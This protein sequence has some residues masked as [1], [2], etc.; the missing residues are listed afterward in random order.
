MNKAT[1]LSL[2]F[3]TILVLGTT[4][5]F[6]QIKLETQNTESLLYLGESEN[7]PLVI[8]LGGSEG[9]N[10]WA[11]DH[12]KTT[13]EEFLRKGYAFLAIGYFGSKGT[14]AI[15]DKIA[16]EDVHNAIL[17]ATQNK[18]INRS[19]I[20]IVGGSR[21]A[22]LALLLG[23]YY[24]EISCIVAIVP[25]HVVFPGH[26][27]HFTS[28][29]WTYQNQQLPFVPVNEESIPFL[30]KNDLRGGFE[31][32]LHD[33]TAEDKALIKVENIN[34][35]ILLLSATKDEIIPSTPMSEKIINRLK[36]KKFKHKAEHIQIDGSHAEPLKHFDKVFSFLD[37]NFKNK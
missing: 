17:A 10:A 26:T 29:C 7:Q 16:I 21:G 13:R 22:D 25:S 1:T 9:G 36:E 34:G 35:S 8:G 30:M 27:D 37:E 2:W 3:L 12:W 31:A 33:Q 24:P 6:A 15:L 11:S 20:A 28:S 4:L 5:S 32:M 19:K 23:S 18:K 14:P